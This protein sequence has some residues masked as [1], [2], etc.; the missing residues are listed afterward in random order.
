MDDILEDNFYLDDDVRIKFDHM[1]FINNADYNLNSPLIRD[2]LDSLHNYINT[3]DIPPRFSKKK[4][5]KE[6]KK[7]VKSLS[8]R[9][10]SPDTIPQVFGNF[11]QSDHSQ[12]GFS[13]LMKETKH[14]SKLMADIFESFTKAWLGAPKAL[15][16]KTLTYVAKRYGQKFLD[17]HVLILA[18]NAVEDELK[19][20]KEQWKMTKV[21]EFLVIP[22]ESMGEVEIISNLCL[23]P[24]LKLI[25]DRNYLLMMKDVFIARFATLTSMSDRLDKRFVLEDIVRM[26]MFYKF[27]DMYLSQMGNEGYKGLKLVE[28][29][30]N[31]RLCDLA[32]EFRPFIPTDTDFQD[33]IDNE[34]VQIDSPDNKL[35][36]LRDLIKES[37]LDVVLF[38][39]G[40]FRHWGHPFIDYLDGLQKLYDNTHMEKNID[41]GYANVLASDLAY[42][43]L[44]NQFDQNKK[45][46]VDATQL[47]EKHLLKS[48]ILDYTWPTPA[49]IEQFGDNWHLL[50]LVKCFEIPDVIDPSVLYSDKSHS[51]GRKEVYQHIAEKRNEPVPSK[52]VLETLLYTEAINW[53]EFLQRINDEGLP[54]DQLIIGLR[55][56][57]RE[58]K[59][60][61]RYFALLAWEFRNYIVMS[62]YLTKTHY[63]KLFDGLTM[64]DDMTEVIK[65]TMDSSNGQGLSDYSEV[66]IAN[67][68]DYE[69][70]NNHQRLES[71]GPVF[72]V[73]GQFLGY[74]NLFVRTHEFFQQ[75]FFYYSARPD[76]IEF[77]NGVPVSPGP[78][79][80]WH[81][82]AGGLEGLRQKGWSVLNMLVINR[83][84][85]CRNTRIK[86][87]AQGDNQVI[88]TQYKVQENLSEPE[89][90]V[91]LDAIWKNN[92]EIM[93]AVLRGVDKLGLL[94]NQNETMISADYLNYGK[95]PIFRGCIHALESKRW[96][97]VTCVSNDQLP[98][99]ANIMSSVATSALMV[100]HFSSSP[101]DSMSHYIFFGCFSKILLDKHNPAA[102]ASIKSIITRKD[103][104]PSDKN[105]I[106]GCL[107][108]DPSLG[109]ISGT[110]LTRF[111]TRAFP[112]PLTESLT[113]WKKVH[114]T[115]S[116]KWVQQ[117]SK[118]AGNPMVNSRTSPDLS[119]LIEDPTSIH[120][121]KGISAVTILKEEVK[122]NLFR[123]TDQIRNV[124]IRDAIIYSR[125]N[126]ESLI[127][128]LIKSR[129][130]FPRFLNEL[131]SATYLGITDG[132]VS[133][134]QNSRTLRRVFTSHY[135]K[136]IDTQITRGE[137]ASLVRLTQLGRRFGNDM[138]NCSATQADTL[139][140][141]SWQVDIVGTTVPHPM[142]MIGVAEIGDIFCKGCQH[143]QL[144]YI[145]VSI[146]RGLSAY[147][148]MR[149]P[150]MAYLGSRTSE[151]TSIIQPWERETKIPLIKR[152][153]KLRAAISW[154]VSPGSNL[155]NT[156]LENLRCLTGEN[157]GEFV[158]GFRRTGSAIH[159]FH[160]S[161][162]SAGGYAATNPSKLSWMVS[163]TDTFK[164]IEDENYDFMFQSLLLYSQI[165]AGEVHD[166]LNV[167]VVYHFHLS[168][169]GCLREIKE[170]IIET[171]T[172]YTFKDVSDKLR[173][174]RKN[175]DAWG[176]D[177][178]CPK[179]PQGKWESLK[180]KEQ[181]FQ[182]GLSIGFLYGLMNLS[183]SVHAEDNSLFPVGVREKVV[184]DQF[185]GGLL[186]GLWFASIL[187][188]LHR[189]SVRLMKHGDNAILGTVSHMIG[190]LSRLTTAINFFRGDRFQ[191]E[192]ASVPHKTPPS[193]P[194]SDADA[195]LLL[196][197][198]LMKEFLTKLKNN[199]NF[200]VPKKIFIFSDMRTPGIIGPLILAEKIE[201]ILKKT[202]WSKADKDKLRTLAQMVSAFSDQKQELPGLE[203]YTHRLVT[204]DQEIR[205]ALKD[206][207]L[208]EKE[209]QVLFGFEIVGKVFSYLVPFS[210]FG[211][212]SKL[213][214][215]VERRQN[216]CVSG[217]RTAQLATGAHYKLRSIL[218]SKKIQYSDFLCG[219]D[220]SGGL[221]A[222]LLRL[223]KNSRGIFNSLL[224]YES[225]TLKGVSPSGPSAVKAIKADRRC[226]NFN[227][228]WKNPSDLTNK[229]TWDYFSYL[230]KKFEL[231]INLVVL[232][233]EV[234]TVEAAK[235]IGDN[236]KEW[237]SDH[238]V[239][240]ITVIF[241][242]YLT[243]LAATSDNVLNQLGSLFDEVSLNQTEFTSSQSSEV[244]AVFR[245]PRFSHVKVNYPALGQLV[246]NCFCFKDTGEELMRART[247]WS[248]DTDKGVPKELIPD[249]ELEL[250][251]LLEIAGMETGVAGTLS[252]FMVARKRNL[253]DLVAMMGLLSNSVFQHTFR[254]S[255]SL[256]PPSD[257]QVIDFGAAITGLGLY[258][259][260]VTGSPMLNSF[261]LKMIEL[262]FPVYWRINKDKKKRK[263]AAWS[264]CLEGIN[265]TVYISHKIANIGQWIRIC[266]RLGIGSATSDPSYI[267]SVMTG[268]NKRLN[269]N[270]LIFNSGIG[271]LMMQMCNRRSRFA[272]DV[273]PTDDVEKAWRD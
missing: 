199:K 251:T 229:E 4:G 203:K 40:A 266:K 94:I 204:V 73:M 125:E 98:T 36:L 6:L 1:T 168:C 242:T 213:D 120:I 9:L 208:K 78:L 257:Q 201:P 118:D 137:I 149:G 166:G 265:K 227:S 60:S 220:G 221:T 74:P 239:I 115:S 241:K 131:K 179:L 148:K 209:K 22:T 55:A 183:R 188:V 86:I 35:M 61:G 215:C 111:L 80:C 72:K 26:E 14:Q 93:R 193:Y 138:W 30:C 235:V 101:L 225:S 59:I 172:I 154:F 107:F 48:Y 15:P 57:E 232:D 181:S 167:S 139:R 2:E 192:F 10:R 158:E 8:L 153:A 264:C 246:Q 218:Q 66:C 95:I 127:A 21:G 37:S 155:A 260:I 33:F 71:N 77:R 85:Q 7:R 253:N 64:A 68:I 173:N 142:E 191:S 5:W 92:K 16:T 161:R 133:L 210:S 23:I 248:M 214:L 119:R 52:K 146:P 81:G 268:R 12:V 39:Y 29:I 28:P 223:N 182:V 84:S 31:C 32:W 116:L 261:F 88:C 124:M 273:C 156:I 169:P 271:E 27:G 198:Y 160:C 159:R 104:N 185:L 163:T 247:I 25:L 13:D 211:E 76:L 195:G 99:F 267:Q 11:C 17:I 228:C 234:R 190:D 46:F 205:H 42:L 219:G 189:R 226:I 132:L 63:V 243:T 123:M 212:S 244:Y 112:D 196:R 202:K 143:L 3:D 89:L 144:D 129:P 174:W 177:R 34:I 141:L 106:A 231:K 262:G 252:Q 245:Y 151:T 91:A 102:R 255:V 171:P 269:W 180:V 164:I 258:M 140:K 75:S 117:V 96:S 67:H 70:W 197:N 45:W 237:L 147:K 58:L 250:A 178:K 50:P 230:I 134:F 87:L 157:W 97:R 126:S 79:A 44:K 110:S 109:G 105:Y 128:F 51:M 20:L 43:V 207:K 82:Q 186:T 136:E 150:Y 41:T 69:K 19:S 90:H 38:M 113:F 122:K 194:T 170:P 222:L 216:P 135:R 259:S 130:L 187:E 249:S 49:V 175:E 103:F 217:L 206:V 184:P 152:A 200:D 121:I 165:T 65:K 176:M 272:Y 240:D 83:E 238:S 54:E 224:E 233:M 24:R 100:S 62:E 47:P 108:L 263:N 236:L 145:T 114:D 254:K 56:K 162:V 53:P 256:S 18:M 270:H